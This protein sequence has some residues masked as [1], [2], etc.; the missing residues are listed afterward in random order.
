[1]ERNVRERN[2]V[3]RRVV[4]TTGKKHQSSITF[5]AAAAYPDIA[6]KSVNGIN[7][8]LE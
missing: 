6:A 2:Q 4:L 3:D 1:M 5:A 7:P 8:L